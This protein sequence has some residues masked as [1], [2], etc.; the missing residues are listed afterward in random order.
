[1]ADDVVL[2]E[3]MELFCALVT[4]AHLGYKPFSVFITVSHFSHQN[5][6]IIKELPM[7]SSFFV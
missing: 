1:M 5:V 3:E 4:I 2:F 6:A 7:L